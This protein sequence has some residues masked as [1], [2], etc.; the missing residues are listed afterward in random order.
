MLPRAQQVPKKALR[1]HKFRVIGVGLAI[2][3]VVPFYPPSP[4]QPLQGPRLCSNEAI[5]PMYRKHDAT[6]GPGPQKK[7]KEKKKGSF[8][9]Q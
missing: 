6:C 7:R 2:V 3:P 1:N 4:E 5:M 9:P 8:P